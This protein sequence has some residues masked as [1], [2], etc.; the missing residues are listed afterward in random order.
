MVGCNL[1]GYFSERLKLIFK[2]KKP[3]GAKNVIL[4]G[5]N[6]QVTNLL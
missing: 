1:F 2:S 3:F 6:A 4:L 5:D